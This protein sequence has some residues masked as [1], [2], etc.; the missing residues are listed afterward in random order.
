M[1]PDC[2]LAVSFKNVNGFKKPFVDILYNFFDRL[3]KDLFVFAG[4]GSEIVYGKI[5]YSSRA[6]KL[7]ALAVYRSG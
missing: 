4:N 6:F 7:L 5:R 1:S 2:N 3:V